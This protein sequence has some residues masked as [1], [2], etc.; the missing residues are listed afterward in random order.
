[1]SITYEYLEPR[2][3]SAYRQLFVKNT[4][5]RAELIYRAHVNAEEPMSAEELA[6]DYMLPLEA[7]VEAIEYCKSNPPE[8][9]A[10]LAR[11]QAI[12]AATGQLE[13]DYKFHPQPK[14]LSPQDWARLRS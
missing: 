6:A 7:V 4:R 13:S 3:K 8:I 5:I 14:I 10:D 11:E 2:P 9:S 12:M 1:M